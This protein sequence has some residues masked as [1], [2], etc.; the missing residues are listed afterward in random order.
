MQELRV[1]TRAACGWCGAVKNVLK[2]HGYDWQEI[3]ADEDDDA[4][5]FLM[6]Q[7]AFTFPQVFVGD[8]R[9]GGYEATVE[10]IISGELARL[11]EAERVG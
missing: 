9:I 10:A 7:M 1:Y 8:H 3:R 6:Q 4:M 2:K 5:R 11:L